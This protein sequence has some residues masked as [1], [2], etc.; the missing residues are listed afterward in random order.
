MSPSKRGNIVNSYFKDINEL[1]EWLYEPRGA[2]SERFRR[3]YVR[4]GQEQ[5]AKKAVEEG[6]F[7]LSYVTG[8]QC[9]AGVFKITGREL[10]NSDGDTAW[11]RAFGSYFDVKPIDMLRSPAKCFLGRESLIRSGHD[12]RGIYNHILDVTVCERICS[13]IKTV[14]AMS[15]GDAEAEANADSEFAD[16]KRSWKEALGRS[17]FLRRLIIEQ[18]GGQCSICEVT[19]QEWIDRILVRGKWPAPLAIDR[20]R[21]DDFELLHAHHRDWVKDG[22]TARLANLMAVCPNCHDLLTRAGNRRKANTS[23]GIHASAGELPTW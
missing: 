3:S 11:D 1:A 16:F 2:D 23:T 7:L 15:E 10:R 13:R 4:S 8:I 5:R 12:G 19:K 6:G 9:W 20:I 22:G 14:A 17:T 18:S 21:G